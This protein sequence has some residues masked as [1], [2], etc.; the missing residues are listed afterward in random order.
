MAAVVGDDQAGVGAHGRCQ[1]V[2]IAGI[3]RHRGYEGVEALD[4][5]FREVPAQLQFPP[6]RLLGR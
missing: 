3:V 1:N 4:P 6:P 2:A 5:R